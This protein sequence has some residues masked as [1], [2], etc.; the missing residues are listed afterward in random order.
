MKSIFILIV[1][2]ITFSSCLSGSSQEQVDLEI[3]I[4]MDNDPTIY[5]SDFEILDED[6][7]ATNVDY[8]TGRIRIEKH[9]AMK[10]LKSEKLHL[11]FKYYDPCLRNDGIYMLNLNSN[12]LKQEYFYLRIYNFENYPKILGDSRK[13]G[14]EYDSPIGSA[15]LPTLK[16]KK[17]ERTNF[18]LC[19]TNR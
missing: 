10:L 18:G 19:G 16:N 17:L 7:N 3:L 13:F 12:L 5:L 8:K 14:F 1:F 15:R 6:L 2:I 9:K 4:F 11:K